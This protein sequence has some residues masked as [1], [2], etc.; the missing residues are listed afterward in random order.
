MEEAEGLTEPEPSCKGLCKKLALDENISW[1]EFCPTCDAWI[2]FR[3]DGICCCCNRSWE[4]FSKLRGIDDGFDSDAGVEEECQALEKRSIVK[5]L[6]SLKARPLTTLEVLAKFNSRNATHYLM[7]AEDL[8]LVRRYKISK[9]RKRFVVNVLTKQG[10]EAVQLYRV[11]K[12]LHPH[13]EWDSYRNYKA[14]KHRM[15]QGRLRAS[16]GESY[17]DEE[18]YPDQYQRR[19]SSS[20]EAGMQWQGQDSIDLPEVSYYFPEERAVAL[21]E[22]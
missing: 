20:S 4:T 18:N 6:V 9:G 11:F 1:T 21:L 22:M 14:K 15:M 2:V 3:S 16:R 5:V 7:S 8:G 10:E 19:D 13:F 17:E 12:I